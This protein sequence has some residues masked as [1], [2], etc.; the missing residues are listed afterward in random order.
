MLDLNIDQV[1]TMKKI[2][3]GMSWRLAELAGYFRWL[4]LVLEEGSMLN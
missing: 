2:R 1:Q 4:H 3:P